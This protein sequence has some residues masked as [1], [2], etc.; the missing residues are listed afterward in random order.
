MDPRSFFDIG[1][2][3]NY[4]KRLKGAVIFSNPRRFML[5]GWDVDYR[6]RMEAAAEL[7]AW[8]GL[9]AGQSGAL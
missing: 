6:T 1:E 7:S 5:Q 8:R 9:P 3:A 2:S 4:G